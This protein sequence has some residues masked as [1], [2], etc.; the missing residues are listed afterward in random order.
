MSIIS[1]LFGI[2]WGLLMVFISV[3]GYESIKDKTIR[4]PSVSYTES[5]TL[6]GKI[7]VCLIWIAV[8]VLMTLGIGELYSWFK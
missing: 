5:F 7:G 6:P 3:M 4:Y 2:M 1:A 8:M